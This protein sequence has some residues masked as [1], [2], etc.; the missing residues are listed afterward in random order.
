MARHD[1]G[2]A[3]LLAALPLALFA[4]LSLQSRYFGRWLLPAYPALALLA[5][6]AL[7]ELMRR[8]AV[9]GSL[10]PALGLVALVALVA[11]PIAADVR[12]ARLLGK[13]DTRSLARRFLV[14]REKTALRIVIEPAVPARYYRL[15]RRGETFPPSRKQFVRG[16]ARDVRETRL[17]YAAT[18][19]PERIDAYRNNGYCMVMTF[20]VIRGRAE[21][22]R[23]PAAASYYR[24][25]ERESALVFQAD[26]YKPGRGPVPFHFDLSYNYFPTAYERPG[27]V[28]RIYR[29]RDCVQE[30]GP[31]ERG[32]GKPVGARGRRS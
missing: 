6:V 21:E 12:T 18:L 29:L 16:F 30:Y 25:L 27:P 32:S 20:S 14:E 31:T 4:Y 17:D 9:R 3:L 11:Q 2:R 10:R 7:G 26:P 22:D 19:A 15:V 28:V 1:A 8:V 23:T 5:G 13:E 24:R